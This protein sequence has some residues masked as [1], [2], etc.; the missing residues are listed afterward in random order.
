MVYKRFIKKDGKTIGPYFYKSVRQKDGSVK[1]VYIG[2]AKETSKNITLQSSLVIF[3]AIA[4]IFL[5]F[6]MFRPL[7]TGYF[8]YTQET[9]SK[10]LGISTSESN[11]YDIEIDHDFFQLSSLSIS[12]SMSGDKAKVY[13]EYEGKEYLIGEFSGK[14]N[15]LMGYAISEFGMDQQTEQPIEVPAEEAQPEEPAEI[16]IEQAAIINTSQEEVIVQPKQFNDACIETCSLNEIGLGKTKL[17]LRIEVDNA[18]VSI[19]K[20]TYSIVDLKNELNIDDESLKQLKENGKAKVIVD[21]KKESKGMSVQQI[22]REV[23]VKVDRKFSS[24]NAIAGEITKEDLKNLIYDGKI[25]QIQFDTVNTILLAQS[26]P[27]INATSTWSR[28]VNGV[29]ITGA[30][31]TVCIIDTGIAEHTALQG[32]IIGKHC[33]CSVSGPC[34]PNGQAEDENATDD[35]SHGTHVSGIIASQ[36]ASYR[37]IAPGAKIVMVKVCDSAGYCSS[38]DMIAGVEFCTNNASLYNIS[39][40][41]ISIGGGGY[42]DYCDSTLPAMTAAIN[43][44]REKGILVSVASGNNGYTDKMTWPACIKNATSVMA[45]DKQDGIAAYSNRN[46]LIDLVAPGGSSSNPIISTILNNQFGGKYGTSMACP[47][48]SGVTA[49]L[50]Q[51]SKLYNN[52][53]LSPEKIEEILRK[54][55]KAVNESGAVYYRINILNAVNSI[56]KLNAAENSVEKPGQAKI[57]FLEST[58]LKDFDAFSIDNNFISMDASSYPSYNKPAN[59]T[60]YNLIFNKAPIILKNGIFCQNCSV[61]NY[62]N[63]TLVFR[64]PGFSNYTS[65]I[66][67][68]LS[69]FNSMNNTAII[70]QNVVFYANYTSKASNQIIN[71]TCIINLNN[72]AYPMILEG[73]YLYNQSFSAWGQYNYNIT[74]NSTDFETLSISDSINITKL[75]PIINFTLNEK[76]GNATILPNNSVLI[77]AVLIQPSGN[78]KLYLNDSLINEGNNLSNLT[79]FNEYGVFKVTS[80]FEGNENYSASAITEWINVINDTSAPA[81][82][83]LKGMNAVYSGIYQLNATWQDNVALDKAWIE[84]N[85]LG[86]LSNFS[87]EKN[88]DEYYYNFG[89]LSAGNYSFRFWAND[90]S[91]N[92]N[93]T[94]LLSLIINKSSNPIALSINNVRGNVSITYGTQSNA[95][96]TA[97]G[98]VS[99][100]RDNIN[101]NNPDVSTLPVKTSGYAYKANATGNENYTD[102]SS[103]VTYYLFIN[104]SDP[105]L[106]LYFNSNQGDL[107][108][109]TLS[110]EIKAV[111]NPQ[112]NVDIYQNDVL[113]TSGNSPLTT[114]KVYNSTGSYKITASFAGN[115]NYSAKSKTNYIT[116][117]SSQQLTQQQTQQQTQEQGASCNPSWQ[118]SEWR[119]CTLGKKTRTCS[120]AN[121]CGTDSGKPSETVDCGCQEIWKCSVWSGCS[122]GMKTRSCTDLNSCSPDK[123]ESSLC[124][125]PSMPFDLSKLAGLEYVGKTMNYLGTNALV[126]VKKPV[127]FVAITSLIIAILAIIFRNN[128]SN[129]LRSA[130]KYKIDVKFKIQ[131]RKK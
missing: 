103:G 50:Q 40:I 31:E 128:V 58:D 130:K 127:F 106:S 124:I 104:K 102:N 37:G 88:N 119:S 111:L 33:Y 101:V 71:G 32:K 66:N 90:S 28:Q 117:T 105:S 55:G 59:I 43:A 95:A 27:Q 61:L 75:P 115:E 51:Y 42:S 52:I 5:L 83:S 21:L 107:T 1:S 131:K 63:G 92:A 126:A 80:L 25:D 100:F 38:S 84:N 46:S 34:C 113:I 87:M 74:C 65:G 91:G 20:L 23:D 108:T 15:G 45:V 13:L 3:A 129:A 44:A 62:I 6:V 9:F 81:F 49:L 85:F 47:H 54:N 18:E 22:G 122:N 77:I 19:S 72:S 94:D 56:P 69:A 11:I 14:N 125:F 53:S 57:K 2:Q 41:S 116:I 118:C 121:N 30:G 8:I 36:D 98:N 70:N 78:L 99:L 39:V 67:A 73:I 64:V 82:S 68:Q 24:S 76:A 79:A 35:N 4:S 89:N 112:S 7:I 17:K 10:D 16:P 97:A 93:S 96:A 109:Q 110:I 29:N 26:A 123:T 60:F 120:D 48:A 114:I 86:N 12:G